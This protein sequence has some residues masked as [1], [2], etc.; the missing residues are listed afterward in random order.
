MLHILLEDKGGR[1]GHS[2]GVEH[3]VGCDTCS[4]KGY[5]DAEERA[6]HRR[7]LVGCPM[8]VPGQPCCE[9][10]PANTGAQ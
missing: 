7:N 4:G 10:N 2:C 8:A 9:G 6:R 1:H 3:I 5:I